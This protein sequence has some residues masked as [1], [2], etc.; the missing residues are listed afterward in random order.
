MAQEMNLGKNERCESKFEHTRKEKTMFACVRK[1]SSIVLR[2]LRGHSTRLQ[3]LLQGQK[4]SKV[5]S[6]SDVPCQRTDTP[7]AHTHTHTHTH[8]QTVELDPGFALVLSDSKELREVVMPDVG[9]Q[10]VSVL[11]H[12]P[13]TGGREGHYHQVHKL[14]R[15]FGIKIV[16]VKSTI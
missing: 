2:F 4:T 11:V 9:G 16:R 10:G 12:H 7:P 15:R 13:V 14:E 8:L 6:V 5:L 3:H 1:D